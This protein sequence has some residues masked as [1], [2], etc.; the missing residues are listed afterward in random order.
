M[1]TS[2]LFSSTAN[3]PALSIAC[4][5]D[6]LRSNMV[7]GGVPKAT[8]LTEREREICARSARRFASAV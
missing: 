6:D 4:R 3:S 2:A 1:A 5:P 7:R 8:D